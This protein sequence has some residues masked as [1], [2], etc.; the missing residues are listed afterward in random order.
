MTPV[1]PS[2]SRSHRRNTSLLK[3]NPRRLM[4]KCAEYNQI[5]KAFTV[6]PG[7]IAL[8]SINRV[9]SL[10]RMTVCSAAGSALLLLVLV[11]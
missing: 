8:G 3:L 5:S 4:P 9:P 2:I 10:S 1:S 6:T 11:V 7:A